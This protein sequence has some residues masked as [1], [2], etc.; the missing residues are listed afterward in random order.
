M[1]FHLSRRRRSHR[2][3]FNRRVQIKNADSKSDCRSLNISMAGMAL[4]TES[5]PKE[6]TVFTL[7]FSLPGSIQRIAAM[8]EVAW[9]RK[10]G[11]S[12]RKYKVGLRFIA[13]GREER[14]EIDSFVKR[15]ERSY[16]DLHFLLSKDQWQL[17]QIHKL[18]ERSYLTPYKDTQELKKRVNR[19]M[20][21]F[22]A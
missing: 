14:E 2:A 10:L 13:L 17:E 20:D 21:G 6:G 16:R 5:M 18:A 12:K 9:T 8:S 11:K 4:T 19:A 22:R 3:P 1:A 15:L 7:T